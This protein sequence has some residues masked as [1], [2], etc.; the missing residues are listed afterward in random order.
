MARALYQWD[1][2]TDESY[3]LV[4]N[5]SSVTYD[6]IVDIIA[7]VYYDKYPQAKRD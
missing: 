4:L 1:P 7:D 3:D 6:Q 2:N 5:T